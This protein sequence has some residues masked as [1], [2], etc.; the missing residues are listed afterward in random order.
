MST[1]SGKQALAQIDE[2][3]GRA[4]R[5][6]TDV[7]AEFGGA[8]AALAKLKATEIGHYAA[9]ARLRLVAIEQGELVHALDD[10]D[11]EAAAILEEREAATTQLDER[12]EAAEA[13]LDADET[14]RAEQQAVVA[15]ASEALD[16]AEADAQAALAADEAY[17][18]QLER[19]EQTDFV[20]DQAED[21]AVAARQD[22]IEKGKP[23]EAD[24]LF[25]YLWAR[26]YG[27]SK[28]RALPL[29]RWLDRKVAQLCD[30]EAAR[31]DYA[32]L[33][34]I[35]LRLAEH[36]AARRAVFDRDGE[37]LAA[38][39][40][41]A[42]EAAG[43]PERKRQLEAA[44]Q[45]LSAIDEAIAARE[46]EIRALVAERGAFAA[47]EDAHYK[48]CIDVLSDAMRRE[49]IG[50]LRERA[51]R[52]P[53]R[54]DDEIV[55]RL[56]ELDDEADRL[57]QNLHELARLHESERRRAAELEDVRRR[58]KAQRYDDPRS[59]FR[60]WALIALALREFLRGAAGSGDV[61][62]TIERQQRMRRVHSD[63]HF[64]SMRFPRAPKHGPWRMPK[65]GFGGGGF[66]TGG[67]F[68]RGG[69]KT[70]GGF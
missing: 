10:A 37:A 20:A 17:R 55:R 22:R 25:A 49:R 3:L 70:G 26:G 5:A 36:A 11:R 40:E 57:E 14:R 4:R 1:L 6:L 67:G 12:I 45:S 65:G 8:R 48:R 2:A 47:G 62:R 61:W 21:K 44:E 16:A 30:Y 53:E 56:A 64:G 13:A 15:A 52:T 7:D 42:A 33:I 69:F 60:D 34:E 66:R 50:F 41:A 9:L 24:P 19:T 23:Y 28:Y 18:A 51:S 43:V 39:E 29:A 31:R 32:L 58:F 46:D 63:P 59:E 35:P 54:A 68:G 27:T 38:L